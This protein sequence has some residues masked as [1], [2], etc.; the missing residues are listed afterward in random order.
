MTQ[1]KY[2]EATEADIG[3]MIEVTDSDP[4]SDDCLW[5][6]RVLFCVNENREFPFK[7]SRSGSWKHARIE[8]T[9]DPA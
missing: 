2:R 7:T 4:T 8:A 5:V 6:L 9:N 3:C 1:R